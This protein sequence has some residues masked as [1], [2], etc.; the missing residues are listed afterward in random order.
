MLSYLTAMLNLFV[1][2]YYKLCGA[3]LSKYVDYYK[4]IV[5]RVEVLIPM[6]FNLILLRET[7]RRLV[8]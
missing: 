2:S 6:K 7:A 8:F 5:V 3:R 4:L 1:F